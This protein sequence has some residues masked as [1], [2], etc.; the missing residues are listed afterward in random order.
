[1]KNSLYRIE[2]RQVHPPHY[3]YLPSKSLRPLYNPHHQHTVI[4]RSRPEVT[5]IVGSTAKAGRESAAVL[6]VAHLCLHR[7]DV[8]QSR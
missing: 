5:G 2:L 4:E 8:E 7:D 3:H 6:D 1:M